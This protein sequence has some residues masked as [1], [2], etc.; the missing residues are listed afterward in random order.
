MP[1]KT[2]RTKQYSPAKRLSPEARKAQLL[3]HAL[4][5]FADAGIERAVHADVAA[6]ANVSTPT[7][8]KYFPSRDDLLD[9]ILNEIEEEFW[10]LDSM[11]PNAVNFNK[12][13]LPKDLART[14]AAS[15]SAL[16]VNRP[17][18]MKVALTW[19]V[20]FSSIRKRYQAFEKVRLDD[21][22]PS[23]HAAGLT[24]SD[25]RVFISSL[26]LFIR[27]HFDGTS[28]EARTRYIISLGEMFDTLPL[29]TK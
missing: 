1:Q 23:F 9:A 16:C 18:L 29:N 13:L 5:A 6:R 7:V 26:F 10:G 22:Q 4:A 24:R 28:S 8:F 14:L 3:E 12:M 20:A 15:I 27:M 19:S 21:L 25:A 11:K 17:N 2:I